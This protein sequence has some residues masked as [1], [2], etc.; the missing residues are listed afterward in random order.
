[1]ILK[2]FSFCFTSL[3]IFIGC[4]EVHK[5]CPGAAS[6]LEGSQQQTGQEGG[7]YARSLLAGYALRWTDPSIRNPFPVGLP[8]LVMVKTL[9]HSASLPCIN[10]DCKYIHIY[11]HICQLHCS[12]QLLHILEMWNNCKYWIIQF[13]WVRILGRA[14]LAGSALSFSE[15]TVN[16]TS[17]KVTVAWRGSLTQAHVWPAVLAAEEPSFPATWASFLAGPSVSPWPGGWLP[18]GRRIQER[19]RQKWQCRLGLS[20]GVTVIS[21]TF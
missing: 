15:A 19:A 7:V 2:S 17:A 8:P 20:L 4:W 21:T 14:S 16:G 1:M 13:S 5:L 3:N 6:S 11:V 12:N 18:P 10:K 9:P